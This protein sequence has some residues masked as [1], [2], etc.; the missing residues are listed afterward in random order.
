MHRHLEVSAD[1]CYSPAESTRE[2]GLEA[3]DK[4]QLGNWHH[5][6]DKEYAES[7][8]LFMPFSTI[9]LYMVVIEIFSCSLLF[10]V[11]KKRQ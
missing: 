2:I 4:I 1:S 10:H 7:S 11:E 5:R 3:S 9:G 8:F 6:Y